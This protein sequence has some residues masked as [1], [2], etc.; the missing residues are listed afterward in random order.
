MFGKPG[1]AQASAGRQKRDGIEQIG[2]ARAVWSGK[3]NRKP[4]D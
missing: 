1:A 3:H 4:A 2:F